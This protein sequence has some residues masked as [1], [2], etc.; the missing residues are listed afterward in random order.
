MVSLRLFLPFRFFLVPEY[1]SGM[2]VDCILFLTAVSLGYDSNRYDTEGLL[3]FTNGI[4]MR[5]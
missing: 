1:L 2:G 4:Y 5:Y 3:E